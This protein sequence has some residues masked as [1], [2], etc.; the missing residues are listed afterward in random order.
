MV[1]TT[2]A[3]AQANE[4]RSAEPVPILVEWGRPK[5]VDDDGRVWMQ[6]VPQKL[7]GVTL[8]MGL[9]CR[10]E[11]E[12][13]TP[14]PCEQ[15]ALPKI[16]ETLLAYAGK[17][18]SVLMSRHEPSHLFT[19][20]S[21]YLVAQGWLLDAPAISNGYYATA[22]ATAKRERRGIW[23]VVIGSPH[24]RTSAQR[25][26]T[27]EID[28]SSLGVALV[29]RATPVPQQVIWGK[30]EEIDDEGRVILA[31]K[32]FALWGVTVPIGITCVYGD[33]P[34]EPCHSVLKPIRAALRDHF[35][36]WGVIEVANEPPRLFSE[37]TERLVLDG[38]LVDQ[39]SSSMGY[40]APDQQIAQDERR[41]FGQYAIAPGAERHVP[42]SDDELKAASVAEEHVAQLYRGRGA[43]IAVKAVSI[44][45]R[46]NQWEVGVHLDP[47]PFIGIG[48]VFVDKLSFR[49]SRAA[50]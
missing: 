36:K 7:W 50:H 6:V 23:K 37:M 32:V 11:D 28:P 49:A 38:W 27:S 24:I 14:V 33:G 15:L 13:K 19:E 48:R 46:G 42:Q 30:P 12:P 21:E 20:M 8:P 39:P 25:A 29:H 26:P 43:T 45:D 9:K 34:P 44:L 4:T 2:G 17:W 10:N 18:T 35:G 40:Y 5:K 41:G 47:I 22:M 1:F 3:H 16:R 31:G